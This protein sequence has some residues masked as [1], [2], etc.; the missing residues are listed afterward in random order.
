MDH[1]NVLFLLPCLFSL[2]LFFSSIVIAELNSDKQALL[3]FASSLHHGKKLN[4]N[5][6]APICSSWIGV[7]CTADKARVRT[8]RLPGMGLFG[9]I[10]ANSIGRLD[11]LPVLPSPAPLFPPISNPTV[12]PPEA[13][14]SAKRIGTWA[15][16]AIV[17][18]GLSILL[19][20]VMVLLVCVVKKN[21]RETS[22][23]SKQKSSVSKSEKP[24]EE[25]SSGA[26]DAEKN[27]L[28]FFEGYSYNFDLEDLLR[29]SAEI[30]G[31]GIYGTS[32][33]AAL[34]DGTMVVVK[35]LKEVI[36]GRREFEQQMEI[37]RRLGMHLNVLSI[38]AY[39][40]SKD[41]KLLVYDFIPNGS[42]SSLLHGNRGT[43]RTS[44][45]WDS[46]VK[47]SLGA[48]HGIAHIHS[49]GG[50]KFVHGNIKSS[51]VL[52]SQNFEACVSDFGLSSL[53]NSPVNRS[54]IIVGYLAPEVIETQKPTQK[55]DI[56][57]FGVL[58][59]EMLT[60][61]SPLQSQGY[62]DI[63]DLP[64][65]VQSV[66]QEEWT[67]EVFDAE[68]LRYPNIEEEMVQ[69]LQIAV[70][71]VSRSPEQRPKIK[72]VIRMI[73]EIWQPSSGNRSS[74][75]EKVTSDVKTVWITT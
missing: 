72:D 14:H 31:K 70:A 29:A 13:K 23:A 44:L 67:S 75:E 34:E 64:R 43:G 6:T 28:S 39:Y 25:S 74:A 32:Y 63:V 18:G 60:G 56:Y 69:M 24:K 3:A 52:V 62:D 57:S 21:G 38:G 40:Y 46:R 59:L 49:E 12:I 30:L 4:W 36:S 50:G 35:R 9:S 51:N 65:W 1:S 17:A 58:L 7:K 15:I 68:L 37:I 45:D 41:E 11:A 71:C 8:V 42:F 16:I 73:E 48:A 53:M 19:L 26:Q 27:K 55:S 61:K 47:I 5:S 2:L 33:K 10:P 22:E 66:V 20:L 54:R